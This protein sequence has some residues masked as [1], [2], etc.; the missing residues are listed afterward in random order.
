MRRGLAYWIWAFFAKSGFLPPTPL[1][2]NEACNFLRQMAPYIEIRYCLFRKGGAGTSPKVRDFCSSWWPDRGKFCGSIACPYSTS[3]CPYSQK[4]EEQWNEM[5]RFR[6]QPIPCTI[7][8]LGMFSESPAD[9][10][11]PVHYHNSW[12]VQWV[13]GRLVLA[14]FSSLWPQ[15]SRSKWQAAGNAQKYWPSN[16]AMMQSRNDQQYPEPTLHGRTKTKLWHTLV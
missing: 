13:S 3:L 9:T 15:I 6:P 8:I 11:N 4:T 5:L 16:S 7:I 10:T 1:P 14:M 12:N 2:P